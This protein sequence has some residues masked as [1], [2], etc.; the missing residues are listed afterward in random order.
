L[1][2]SPTSTT[3]LAGSITGAEEDFMKYEKPVVL[4]YGSIAGHTFDN[5][6][7]GDKSDF[8]NYATDKY[9]EF[10]HPAS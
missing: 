7:E 4:D 10:S 3:L 6:G 5:P 1:T 2:Q 9:G 8:T